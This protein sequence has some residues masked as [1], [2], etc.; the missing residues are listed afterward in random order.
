VTQLAALLRDR[1]VRSVDLTRMLPGAS[2]AAP[3]G[4]PR[5]DHAHRGARP[6]GG[7]A[8]YGVCL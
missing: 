2:Q 3:S 6:G 8:V 5:R 4:P 1:K 7:G